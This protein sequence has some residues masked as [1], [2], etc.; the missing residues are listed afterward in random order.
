[1]NF[2]AA[3]LKDWVLAAFNYFFPRLSRES[4][5]INLPQGPEPA[6]CPKVMKLK[7]VGASAQHDG[8]VGGDQGRALIGI[9]KSVTKQSMLS[10]SRMAVPTSLLFLAPWKLNCPFQGMLRG[11]TRKLLTAH[12]VICG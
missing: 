10:S 8:A 6:L 1:M 2:Q 4:R 12:H 9:S 3:A 11:S 7:G 5:R